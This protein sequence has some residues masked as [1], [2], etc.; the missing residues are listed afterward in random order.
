MKI[1]KRGFCAFQTRHKKLKKFLSS[2]EANFPAVSDGSYTSCKARSKIRRKRLPF[3]SS[4]EEK[5]HGEK[6]NI[7]QK[8][9]AIFF[10]C[11]TKQ[12]WNYT[13]HRRPS[14][15]W[16][17]SVSDAAFDEFETTNCWRIDTPKRGELIA[18]TR[19]VNKHRGRLGR[20]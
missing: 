3:H 10:T 20:E 17:G 12:K 15:V 19:H 1:I 5:D 9:A 4:I 11:C 6:K 13:E 8:M 18:R 16:Q 7:C 14:Y 2:D